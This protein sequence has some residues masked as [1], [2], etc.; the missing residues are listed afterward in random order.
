MLVSVDLTSVGFD[1][2]ISLFLTQNLSDHSNKIAF[3]CL[4]LRRKRLKDFTSAYGGKG[5][6]K[7][8]HTVNKQEIKHLSQLTRKSPDHIFNRD[9]QIHF[10]APN[11]SL[12]FSPD[13]SMCSSAREATRNIHF[14]SL[15]P[16]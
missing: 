4:E 10:Y 14:C 3:H 1:K 9:G 2:N 6:M 8:Q 7:I 16:I 11:F 5:F 12:D 13:W 15:L